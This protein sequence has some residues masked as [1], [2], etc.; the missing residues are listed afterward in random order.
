MRR[1]EYTRGLLLCAQRNY[2]QTVQVI[3]T[4]GD[5]TYVELAQECC[6]ESWNRI[7]SLPSDETAVSHRSRLTHKDYVPLWLSRTPL[8]QHLPHQSLN[9][10]MRAESEIHH[11][12]NEFGGFDLRSETA[13]VWETETISEVLHSTSAS[14]SPQRKG[15]FPSFGLSKIRSNKK[16]SIETQPPFSESKK[17]AEESLPVPGFNIFRRLSSCPESYL[18]L[19]SVIVPTRLF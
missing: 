2:F 4:A 15:I 11:P 9:D 1:R 8:A 16:V 12:S 19:I 10:L 18:E 13:T 3:A 17:V 7:L 14:A 5:R 6:C